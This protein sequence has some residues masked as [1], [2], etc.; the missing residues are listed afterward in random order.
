[1]CKTAINQAKI[2]FLKTVFSLF[3]E[4]YRNFYKIHMQ[5]KPHCLIQFVQAKE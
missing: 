1:M 4:E 2:L 3:S 5:R